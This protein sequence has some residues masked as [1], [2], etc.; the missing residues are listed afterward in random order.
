MKCAIFS[1]YADITGIVDY[2]N[3]DDMKYAVIFHPFCQF[4]INI[5]ILKILHRY[6]FKM[7]LSCLHTW[8][9]LS[10]DKKT[11]W[12]WVPKCIYSWLHTGI[13]ITI[14]KKMISGKLPIYVFS[15]KLENQY[16]LEIIFYLL[17]WKNMKREASLEVEVEV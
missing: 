17:R 9:S 15:F 8:L 3:H 1:D 12:H 11:W 7:I 13:F 16:L 14:N 6:I 4:F 2:T 10:A 5:L